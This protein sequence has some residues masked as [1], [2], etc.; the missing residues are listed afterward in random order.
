VTPRPALVALV[1]A[2]L[3]TAAA[4]AADPP[5][6]PR[7][8]EAM[9]L[10]HRADEAP[11]AEQAS[12][13]DRALRAAEEAV[14]ADDQDALAH[15]AVFCSLGGNMRLAGA[16]LSAL[17]D[18]FRLRRE[19]DRTLELAPD[20]AD[21]LAGKGALLLDAPGLL[22]GDRREGERLLRRALEID[23]D[24]LGPRLDLARA[25]AA[26]GAR[27]EARAEAERAL[28]IAQRKGP[29]DEA[30][31]RKVLDDLGPTP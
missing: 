18:L 2:L 7:S 6:T 9:A 28:V 31:A 17:R 20:F 14:K 15:F 27:T 16:S 22:G 29:A 8:R 1:A 3:L 10:C 21:A 26:R 24:Y 5:G 13:Y 19:V 4:L 11:A 23:P 30:R 25:L 12:S